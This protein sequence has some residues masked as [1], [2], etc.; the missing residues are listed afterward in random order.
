MAYSDYPQ[1][2]P[3]GTNQGIDLAALV[4][5]VLHLVGAIT[6]IPSL[7][8]LVINY[9]KR[10]DDGPLADSHH[11]WMIHSFWWTILWCIV[12]WIL[13]LVLIGYAVLALAWLWFLYRHVRG[14]IHLLDNRPMPT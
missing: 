7:I 4:A 3:A 2:R 8:A 6:A 14:L 5:Y 12:G 13:T 9:I 11:A 1:T 10:R